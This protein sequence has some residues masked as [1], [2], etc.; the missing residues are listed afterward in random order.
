[1][2]Y[3]EAKQGRIFVLRLENGEVVHEVLEAFARTHAIKN[4]AVMFLGAAQS[5]SRMVSGPADETVRPM[6]VNINVLRAASEAVGV[7][8]IF[9]NATGAPILHMHA[10]FGHK[11]TV[12]TG[13]IRAGAVIWHV[14]EA[15]IFE[16]LDI[17]GARMPDADSGFELLTFKD[18]PK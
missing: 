9:P 7:G 10:S 3:S 11:D 8:T 2:Q 1:M 14:G 17:N 13:C 6:P 15:V 18:E 16:L 12:F 4:A 5:E